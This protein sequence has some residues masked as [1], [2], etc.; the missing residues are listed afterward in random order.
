MI[1]V[2]L[3]NST[4]IGSFPGKR[5]G[6]NDGSDKLISR[7]AL[8]DG[9]AGMEGLDKEKINKYVLKSIKVFNNNPGQ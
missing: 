9:K 2:D 1:L 7:M 8:N 4:G 5:T 3:M 6:K